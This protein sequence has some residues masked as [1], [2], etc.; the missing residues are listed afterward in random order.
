MDETRQNGAQSDLSGSDVEDALALILG[1]GAGSEVEASGAVSKGAAADEAATTVEA[2]ATATSEAT[3]E[4]QATATSEAT[5][6][7]KTAVAPEPQATPEPE[8]A[9]ES[10]AAPEPQAA[11]QKSSEKSEGDSPIRNSE[12]P[13]QP[14]E[15]PDEPTNARHFSPEEPL[16]KKP[17]WPIVVAA[18]II[19]IVV[20]GG[21]TF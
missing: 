16:E 21:L 9:P 14:K 5:A 15:F 8:S 2:A 7:S 3:P 19:F 1:T 18:L 17:A 12:R 20:T 11:S 10:E 13:S 4:P 6:A